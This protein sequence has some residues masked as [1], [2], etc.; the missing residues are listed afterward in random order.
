MR[1]RGR[2]DRASDTAALVALLRALPEPRLVRVLDAV[3]ADLR[4]PGTHQP[5]GKRIPARLCG[6]CQ[7]GY[8]RCRLLWS[9][10]HEWEEP[11]PRPADLDDDAEQ[12]CPEPVLNMAGACSSCGTVIG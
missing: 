4:A 9:E 3:G 6:H 8:V 5:T 11:K 12:C 7:E 1:R 10:D 2:R